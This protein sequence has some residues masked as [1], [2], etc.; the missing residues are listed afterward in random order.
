MQD[1]IRPQTG[2]A[3]Q[4]EAVVGANGTRSNSLP[5]EHIV[6]GHVRGVSN[7]CIEADPSE[8][9]AVQRQKIS[10]TKMSLV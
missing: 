8:I 5:L 6:M 4:P 1:E 7:D 3:R 9:S 2:H 10:L